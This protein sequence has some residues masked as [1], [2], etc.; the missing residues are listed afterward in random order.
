M[1]DYRGRSQVLTRDN[2]RALLGMVP[3]PAEPS[4]LHEADTTRPADDYPRTQ[5]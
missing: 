1:H 3:L 2:E 5:N 4:A